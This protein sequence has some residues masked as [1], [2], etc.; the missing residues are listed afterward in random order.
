MKMFNPSA[1]PKSLNF[2]WVVWLK[3]YI[4]EADRVKK[5]WKTP[6]MVD[7]SLTQ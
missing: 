7:I 6:S 4:V 3:I 5:K 2:I 1:Y